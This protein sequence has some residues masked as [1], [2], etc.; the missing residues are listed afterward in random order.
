M[1]NVC[2]PAAVELRVG[3]VIGTGVRP[4]PRFPLF[5]QLMWRTAQHYCVALDA[6]AAAEERVRR[7]DSP[8]SEGSSEMPGGGPKKRVKR[9]RASVDMGSLGGTLVSAPTP[10]P[11]AVVAVKSKVV[12]K[13][14]MRPAVEGDAMEVDPK[15]DAKEVRS[16]GRD[17]KS[18]V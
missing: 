14:A 16:P 17:A 12:V 2:V 3:A 10:A 7:G 15:R 1:I 8:S 18:L 5:K 6:A 13:I 4:W 9:R 11:A